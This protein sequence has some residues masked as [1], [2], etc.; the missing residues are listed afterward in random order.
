MAMSVEKQGRRPLHLY[1][2]DYLAILA[3]SIQIAEYFE[4]FLLPSPLEI[5]YFYLFM[6]AGMVILTLIGVQGY[7]NKY[8]DEK[9]HP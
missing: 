7:R 3:F 5:A 9:K 4:V 6:L 1:E 8:R 2:Y